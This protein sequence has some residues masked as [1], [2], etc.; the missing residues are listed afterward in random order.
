MSPVHTRVYPNRLLAASGF[1]VGGPEAEVRLLTSSGQ[2]HV[3]MNL[4]G[5]QPGGVVEA[6]RYA[7]V[8]ERLVGLFARVRDPQTGEPVFEVVARREETRPYGLLHEETTGDVWLA[9]KPGYGVSGD[10]GPGDV[11]VPARLGGAHGYL[12]SGRQMQTIFLAAGPGVRKT[13]L[14]V[15]NNIDVA[16]TITRLLGVSPPRDAQGRVLEEIV[17]K[18]E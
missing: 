2:V 1:R 15:V 6:R 9:V 8:V 3:Y 17:V 10:A 7:P 16:P 14:G 12:A 5:R 11:L 18:K 4:A 13:Q